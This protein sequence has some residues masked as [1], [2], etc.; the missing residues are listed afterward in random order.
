MPSI[1]S[2][3]ECLEREVEFK[4]WIRIERVIESMS[5]DELEIL[6]ST[7]QWPNRPDPPPGASR[8][9]AMDRKSQLKLW[10]EA[11]EMFAGRNREQVAFLTRYGHWPEEACGSQCKKSEIDTNFKPGE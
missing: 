9:D 2:R 7:N 3:L 8:L 5:G 11:Q 1:E 6:A 4:A 10:K